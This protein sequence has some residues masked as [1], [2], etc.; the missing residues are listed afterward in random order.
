MSFPSS[1]TRREGTNGSLTFIR[2]AV[3]NHNGNELHIA[4]DQKDVK[5][6][7]KLLSKSKKIKPLLTT[8]DAD[9]NTPLT[10]ALRNNDAEMVE[11]LLQA[12]QQTKADI[13]LR[14]KNGYTALH[15]A[16]ATTD[17]KI[18]LRLLQFD[19]ID[20]DVGNDDKNR[21]LHYFCQ[22]FKSPNCSDPFQIFIEKG[23]N[24]N[25]QNNNGETPLHKAIF[26]NSV[27]LLM[28]DLLLK[29]G[30]DVNLLNSMGESP[31]HYAVRLGR[32]D[33][34]SVL[35][36]AGADV[37]VAGQ[38]EKKTPLELAVEEGHKEMAARI[39]K[40]KELLDWLREQG[41]DQYLNVFVKEELYLDILGDMDEKTL[42]RLGV[43]STGHRI[44]ILKATKALK[45][46]QGDNAAAAKKKD[47]EDDNTP[48]P[49]V[50]PA[51]NE[52]VSN[53]RESLLALKHSG[54]APIIDDSELEFTEK[55]GAGSSGKVYKGLCKGNEVAIKVLKSMTEAKEI[56]EFK[57][58][59][60]IMSAIRSK[61]VVYFYGAVLEPKLCMVMEFCSRG[62]LYHVITNEKYDIGWDKTFHIA[63]NMTKGVECLHNW[64]PQIVHRDFKSLNLLVNEKWEVKVCDFGL[65]RF[66]TGS[67][68]E[69]LVKMR[70]TFAYCAP[71]VYFG[72]QFSTKSDV[73]SIGMVLWELVTRCIT[74]RYERP[75]AEFKNLHFDFQII[76]QTAKK[77]LR[78]TIPPS[79]PEGL[80]QLIRDC[81]DH[82][83]EKRP[84]CSEI[85]QRLFVLQQDW[86][87]HPDV[88]EKA[89]VKAVDGESA[90]TGGASS[91]D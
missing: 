59:F 7:K 74:G 89:K 35:L 69:T 19:G 3:N 56:E 48:I 37:S 73:Y 49:P 1:T 14:D 26:N 43:T 33:L 54:P 45:E 57:K 24:V 41:L 6:V 81:F 51:D 38:R 58:E 91:S 72:E 42:D 52:V 13:N 34:V 47:P 17:D 31:L 90:G 67:N 25:A 85:N 16:V 30:A 5:K 9:G 75:F 86:M 4:V 79:C 28:V 2:P 66:N 18:L 82:S 50:S 78:P 62:S 27:R 23:C 55:L 76:I 70:G 15:M 11:L 22:K 36:K 29:N 53:L 8:F 77:G 68:L 20:V 84:G 32:D 88:W 83:P 64:D 39:K 63:I 60:M 87:D 10:T 80:A 46:K 21:P 12:Y 40:H 71:E 65:S 44:K 61:Y